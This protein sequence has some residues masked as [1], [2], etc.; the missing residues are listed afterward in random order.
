MVEPMLPLP[1][2]PRLDFTPCSDG[3]CRGCQIIHY[4]PPKGNRCG[5]MP[6]ADDA[7]VD[8]REDPARRLFQELDA[9]NDSRLNEQELDGM[10]AAIWPDMEGG[11]RDD[12]VQDVMDIWG[13]MDEDTQEL[14]I[15]LD[16]F[17]NAWTDL[18]GHKLWKSRAR[19]PATGA[20]RTAEERDGTFS[21]DPRTQ[22]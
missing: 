9:D 13:T 16:E 12:M 5:G 10:V 18:G 11:R 4:L 6:Q 7:D 2:V 20:A 22:N 15:G 19:A 21:A 3:E 17:K 1:D 14:S 8:T